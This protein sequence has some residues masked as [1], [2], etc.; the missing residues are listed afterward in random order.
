MFRSFSKYVGCGN[1][2]ILFDHRIPF[3]PIENKHLIQTLCHRQRGIGADGIILLENSSR[4]DFRFRIFNADGSEA[5][6][7][8][9]GMRCL[10]KFI[11]E[12]GGTASSYLI[13]TMQHILALSIQEEAVQVEMGPIKEVIWNLSL[14]VPGLFLIGHF[15]NTGVPHFVLFV[16]DLDRFALD[17]LG[18]QIRRH[19]RFSPAG[20]NVN[21]AEWNGSDTLRIRT[22]ERGVEAETLACGTG[23]TAVALAA[24][25]QYQMKSP[26]FIKTASQELLRIDF[27][28]LEE[29]YFKQVTLTGPAHRVFQGQ[30]II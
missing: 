28:R 27:C 13:E 14:N 6:M 3:F 8:G 19:V 9:N 23:A 2:F 12:C 5:E 4:A 22:Y 29:F 15:L 16:Q 25:Y 24:A 20:T 17:Q 30:I 21:L 7:C 10:G 11:Q 26:I 18:P 1:D